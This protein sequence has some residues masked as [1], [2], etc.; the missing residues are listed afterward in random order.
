MSDSRLEHTATLLNDGR[1]LIVAGG[2][3][4]ESLDDAAR[5]ATAELF[6]P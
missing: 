3:T 5:L 6:L 4:D 2:S 1:V